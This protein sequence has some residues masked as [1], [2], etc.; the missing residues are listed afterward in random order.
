VWD[1][2]K[3]DLVECKVGTMALQLREITR[4]TETRIIVVDKDTSI[5]V[6]VVVTEEEV[7]TFNSNLAVAKAITRVTTTKEGGT[8][9]MAR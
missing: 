7:A 8:I 5:E 2:I 4:M 6:V 3:V 1:T 9:T